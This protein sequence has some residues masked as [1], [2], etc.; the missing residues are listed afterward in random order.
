MPDRP[1]DAT[2]VCGLLGGTFDP[3]H[4]AHLALARAVLDSRIVASLRIVPAGRPPHRAPPVAPAAD[5]LAMVRLAIGSLPHDLAAR[6]E[7][8]SGEVARAAPSYTIDTLERLRTT[9]GPRQ[10]LALILGAD[11]FLGLPTW[12]RW[13]ELLA[14]AHLLITERPGHGLD[15][16][17]LPEAL[18]QVVDERFRA[19]GRE[20]ASAP[21]GLVASFDMPAIDLSAT[22]VRALLAT[23]ERGVEAASKLLPADVVRYIHEHHL[24]S[25]T[26]GYTRTAADRH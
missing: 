10:P 17:R 4:C 12:H 8:D 25:G 1:A 11:A 24:Y 19:D 2:G 26:D 13:D 9:L 5:R 23:G 6:C 16:E 3:I 15:R 7:V 22:R 14:N 21:A 20:L 18:R